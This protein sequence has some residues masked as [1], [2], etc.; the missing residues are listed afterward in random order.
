MPE[1]SYS[2]AIGDH[3]LIQ[4][5]GKGDSFTINDIGEELC[6]N[7]IRDLSI[8]HRGVLK[9]IHT[10]KCI[11]PIGRGHDA[12]WEIENLPNANTKQDWLNATTEEEKKK[13]TKKP[14]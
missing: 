2:Q 12:R 14:A 8:I 13:K 1:R 11:V 6:V 7:D 3:I 4:Q 5:L 9:A 10:M